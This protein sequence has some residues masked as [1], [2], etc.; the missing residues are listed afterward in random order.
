MN[1]K[2]GLSQW[3]L[4]EFPEEPLSP[5]KPR[6]QVSDPLPRLSPDGLPTLDQVD[7]GAK[8]TIEKVTNCLAETIYT[9]DLPYH[10]DATR[11]PKVRW[12]LFSPFEVYLEKVFADKLSEVE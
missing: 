7:P 1:A 4:Y 2:V 5:G 10:G 11:K 3:D 6:L 9:L 12:F 8:H